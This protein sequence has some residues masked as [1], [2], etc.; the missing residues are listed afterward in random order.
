[1]EKASFPFSLQ[2]SVTT[3]EKLL[4]AVHGRRGK[5]AADALCV[6]C[7]TLLDVDAVAICLVFDGVTTG[8]L[9]S[10][11]AR[12]RD[13]GELQ[14]VLGEGPSLESVA[15]RAPVLVDDLA[16]PSGARW[17]LYEPAMLELGIHSVFALPVV[18][19]GEYIGTLSLFRA[20]PGPIAAEDASTAAL[21]AQLARVPLLDLLHTDMHAAVNDPASEAWGELN[22]LSRADVSQATGMLVAQLDVGAAEAL[23]RL[24]AHA[25]STG[26]TAADVARDILERTLELESD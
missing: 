22:A 20:R 15:R 19:A 2:L 1:M 6:A 18:I 17:P 3:A 23:L 12:A 21:A 4:A 9:G 24:R 16:E 10:S 13:Y 14:F 11:D 8:T 7:V 26:R 25:Y 5:D